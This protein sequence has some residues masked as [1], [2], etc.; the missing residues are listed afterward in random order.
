MEELL[1]KWVTNCIKKYKIPN[2]TISGGVAL[3]IKA[4]GKISQIKEVKKLFIGGSASDES[5]ALSAGICLLDK[6]NRSK[7]KNLVLRIS[8]NL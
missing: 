8:T 1:V 3:N 6:I 5:M 7:K 4:M 2:V